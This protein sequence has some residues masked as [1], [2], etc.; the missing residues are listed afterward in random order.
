MFYEIAR[1]S[2][3]LLDGRKPVTSEA[4]ARAIATALAQEHGEAFQIWDN[5]RMID[6]IA[7]GDTQRLN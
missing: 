4:Q 3:G 5:R 7:P 1:N 6:V 2:T